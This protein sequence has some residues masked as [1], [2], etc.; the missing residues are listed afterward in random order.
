MNIYDLLT[1]TPF[2]FLAA[3]AVIYVMAS[4]RY[5]FGNDTHHSPAE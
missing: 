4:W 3:G 1:W 5:W 2:L